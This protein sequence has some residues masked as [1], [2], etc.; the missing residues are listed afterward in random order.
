MALFDSRDGGRTWTKCRI[1][2]VG[3]C[4]YAVALDARDSRVIYVGGSQQGR[5]ALYRSENGGADWRNIT[6]SI[7]GIVADLALDPRTSGTVYAGTP[8]GFFRS[9]NGG[10]SWTFQNVKGGA[11]VTQVA[12]RKWTTL[13]KV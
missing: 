9:R 1:T 5:A 10:Q 7:S 11:K 4:G 8:N 3:G 12:E 2:S 6:G 13:G